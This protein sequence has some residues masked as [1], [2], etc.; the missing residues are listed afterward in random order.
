MVK[1]AYCL[2]GQPRN[3]AEG[4]RIISTFVEK[5]DV[6]FYYHTWTLPNE[7]VKYEHS[8]YRHVKDTDLKYEA[9]IIDK[10]NVL[11]QP[12]TYAV[13]PSVTFTYTHSADF[14][15]SIMYSNTEH[16]NRLNISNALSQYYSKQK[17]RDLLYDEIRKTNVT[18]DFVIC[19]RFDMLKPIFIDLH[20]LNPHKVY[21]SDINLPRYIFS[22]AMV[23]SNVDS[24]LNMF[25]VYNNLHNIINDTDLQRLV[26]TY[27]EKFVF[28]PECLLF[29]NYL[30][31]YKNTDNVEYINIPNLC[32]PVY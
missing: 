29:S 18:Y 30:Y 23:I 7:H 19:S 4:H 17:V 26:E 31:Y 25:N 16:R 20:R 2:Y 9:N 10:I 22:D 14:M 11:Y 28:V 3:L 27:N 24:F 15:N 5:Y 1:I 6:D 32:D 12:K 21:V 13:D 8:H